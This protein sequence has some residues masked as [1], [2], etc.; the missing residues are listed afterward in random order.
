MNSMLKTF[1]QFKSVLCICPHCS[2]LLR[3][4]E[5]QNM[6]TTTPAPKTWLDEYDVEMKKIEKKEEQIEGK[7]EALH[8]QEKELRAKSVARGQKKVKIIVGKSLQNASLKKFNPYD[9]KP[10]LHPVD[11]VIYDGN[12]D[13]EIKKI[14]F[15]SKK[16]EISDLKQLQESIHECV[17]KKN[18]DFREIKV[19]NSGKVGYTKWDKIPKKSGNGFV[20]RPL[21]PE[22]SIPSSI[23]KS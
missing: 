2:A 1:Q 14:I 4:S 19:S 11:F 8:S 12:N 10:I 6:R 23:S 18:Y 15:L 9:I 21:T 20:I 7:E 17:K 16:S 5:I 13:G 22:S 3:L